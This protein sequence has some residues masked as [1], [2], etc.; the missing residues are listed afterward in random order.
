MALGCPTDIQWHLV[1]LLVISGTWLPNTYTARG[2]PTYLWHTVALLELME[3]LAHGC[4]TGVST[5]GYS[6]T[7]QRHTVAYMDYTLLPYDGLLP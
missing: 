3:L 7:S 6:L 2:C 1:A 4:I 5:T